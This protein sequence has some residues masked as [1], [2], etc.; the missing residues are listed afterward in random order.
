MFKR[1]ITII[2]LCLAFLSAWAKMK[3]LTF[4]NP[5]N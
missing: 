4:D 1:L 2:A 3:P 5:G